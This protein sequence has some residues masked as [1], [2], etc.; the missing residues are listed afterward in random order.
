MHQQMYHQVVKRDRETNSWNSWTM[1]LLRPWDPQR[2]QVSVPSKCRSQARER[3]RV[4]L[5]LWDYNSM[6]GMEQVLL[7]NGQ[8]TSQTFTC[9]W[10]VHLPT[11]L[12]FPQARLTCLFSQTPLPVPF[13]LLW[14]M[15]LLSLAPHPSY[16]V[17][18]VGRAFLSL[19]NYLASI[20]QI[21]C[22]KPP[23]PPSWL[24][25]ETP[26]GPECSMVTLRH[27]DPVSIA[28][29]QVNKRRIHNCHWNSSVAW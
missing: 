23:P 29:I 12:S 28:S 22:K 20:L 9:F 16:L 25:G 8:S 17:L 2:E 14:Y 11:N 24:M 27:C 3:E 7:Q 13:R 26:Q 15:H 1:W 5:F 10:W 21:Q 6:G 18:E 4:S 19:S